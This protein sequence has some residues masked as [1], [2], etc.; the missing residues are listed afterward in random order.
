MKLRAEQYE[1]IIAHLPSKS[2]D[3][4]RPAERRAGPR[5]GLR[6]Q[7]QLIPCRAGA[8][9]KVLSAGIRDISHNGIGLILH[10]AIDPG[11]A[12][13]LSLSGSKS[14]TLD[15][16]FDIV[17]CTPLSNGQFSIGAR[18]RRLVTRDDGK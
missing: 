18:F 14:R 17:R 10:E 5:V 11:I 16:L 12:I 8:A 3:R 13:V 4:P 1:K 6:A 15:L 7:I 9:A 2:A